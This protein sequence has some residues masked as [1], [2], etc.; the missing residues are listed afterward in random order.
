[1]YLG[2]CMQMQ[3]DNADM[4]RPQNVV[5]FR[6]CKLTELLFSN[7]ISSHSHPSRRSPQ[8][9]IM[10]VTADPLGDY[11]ATSQILR[12]SALAREVTVPR[13]PSVT[14]TI[15]AGTAA[16]KGFTSASGRTTPSAAQEE[17]ERAL[18][19]VAAM[20]EQLEIAQLRLDEETH[21]RRAAES[22]WKAAEQRMEQVEAE[23]REE[24]WRE[25]EALMQEERRRW[26][27][28]RE[29]ESERND[30]HLDRKLEILTRG[31]I[32]VLEDPEPTV[33]ERVV[34][35]EGE[36]ERLRARLENVEREKG[37]RSPSKKMRVLKSRKWEGSGLG[38]DGSP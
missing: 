11:N 17:L 9:S 36:N 6:Q 38:L 12:Y 10:I 18:L 20:R 24:M 15:L 34:E 14:S 37:L 28:A 26:R 32:E 23:V 33:A 27:A 7:S 8:K 1:M 4:S 19:E 3:S 2:Q 25:T 13:I 5:P 22:S 21:R 29:E 16:A 31:C 30:E 35:L